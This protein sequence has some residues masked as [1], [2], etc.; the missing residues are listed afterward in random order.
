[1]YPR[2]QI[3]LEL[4]SEIGSIYIN[5][6]FYQAHYLKVFMDEI[7]GRDNFQ[8]EIIWRIGW[9]SGFK[10]GGNLDN[11]V[12]NHD[13]ILFY[14]K[15]R[16][17][18]YFNK[19]AAYTTR[20]NF[21]NRF[22]AYKDKESGKIINPISV[23]INDLMSLGIEKQR[24]KE[25]IRK[26]AVIGLPD[27][28]PMED[29]WNCSTYDKL[30]SIG[31]VSF[32]G[33]KVSAMLNSIEF[34]GQKAEALVRRVLS[35]STEPGDIVLDSFAGTGTAAAVAHKM[36]RKYISIEMGNHA[37]T[38]I[39]PRLKKVIRGE[40]NSGITESV[41]WM[42][43]GGFRF[44]TLGDIIFE[45]N[46]RIRKDVKF[47]FLAAHLW[48]F[49]TKTPLKNLKDKSAFLGI[50]KG[51]GYA[52]LYN[53]ILKDKSVNG[54]NVLT[55]KTLSIIKKDIKGNCNQIVIYGAGCRF[56]VAELN[57]R[58][59]IFKQTPYNVREK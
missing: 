17:N 49:E 5:L 18:L 3:L 52:L 46:R 34:K 54:G 4:L 28:Y 42:G 10:S 35:I 41:K 44:Y 30:N 9:V 51:I 48:F 16:E 27:K 15:N 39:V 45:D 19:Q 38:L 59:I 8:R 13:T 40:D 21:Q 14:T 25:F 32:S 2:L 58:G 11:F 24:A 12:R 29:T 53:G 20:D 43:G 36:G 31:I 47:P 23:L 56:S 50:Y 37:K 26:A 1:M 22:N 6:D 7:F 33:E 57:K 55:E